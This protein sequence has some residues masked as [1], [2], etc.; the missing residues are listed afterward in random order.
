MPPSEHDRVPPGGPRGGTGSEPTCRFVVLG[1]THH[2]GRE[3]A[4][5]IRQINQLDADFVVHLGDYVAETEAGWQQIEPMLDLF[6]SP[7]YMLPGNHDIYNEPTRRI[8]EAR[9]GRTFYSFDF[10][11]IHF[12]ALDSELPLDSGER[13]LRIHGEQ[14]AWLA[15]DLERHD[16]APLKFIFVHQPLWLNTDREVDSREC[17]MRDVHPILA[18]HRVSAVFAGHLHKY[19]E[20][21]VIDGVGYY[22]TFSAGGRLFDPDECHGNF[23]HCSVVSACGKQWK[24]AVLCPGA[25]EPPD[26]V[27]IANP[28]TV[29]TLQA[30]N[31]VPTSLDRDSCGMPITIQI[32]NVSADP[33][34]YSAE[35]I[36]DVCPQWRFEPS[37]RSVRLLPGQSATLDFTATLA[38]PDRPYPGPKFAID[39]DGLEQHTLRRTQVVP[40][41]SSPQCRCPRAAG[42]ATN[43]GQLDEAAWSA[44]AGISLP[45]DATGQGRPDGPTDV[46]LGWDQKHLYLRVRC[47]EPH[48]QKLVCDAREDGGQTW[49]DDSIELYLPAGPDAWHHFVW[50]AN[51]VLYYER[52]REPGKPD[53]PFA[54]RTGHETDAWTLEAAFDMRWIGVSSP[55][56]GAAIGFQIVRNRVAGH[57]ECSL[58]A[59]TFG[60]NFTPE[61]FGKILLT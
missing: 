49:Y 38:E 42:A 50:N 12:V 19:I 16:S 44:C 32:T 40:F 52:N 59:P 3:V 51:G 11:A 4:A 56:R 25:I 28:Y 20:S 45:Y 9:F 37:R 5:Q 7:L 13:S 15:R 57:E 46:R 55:V 43:V 33:V 29:R 17:W 31:A 10:N 41:G 8:Y 48:L 26:C 47:M 60:T 58:W 2:F 34:A 21:P 6:E 54:A 36:G 39:V 24:L 18:R 23:H 61:F 53:G 35:P 22:V 14:L 1:D 30:V 27:R